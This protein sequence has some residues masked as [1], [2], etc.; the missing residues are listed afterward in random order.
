MTFNVL[1]F[2]A[3]WDFFCLIEYLS[4]SVNIT[5]L[6]KLTP[7]IPEI[8][9]RDRSVAWTEM[10]SWIKTWHKHL[11]F[12]MGMLEKMYLLYIL[13][14][15]KSHSLT[16][17]FNWLY[18]RQNKKVLSK[19]KLEAIVLVNPDP[20][21]AKACLDEMCVLGVCVSA[22]LCVWTKSN[23]L[24]SLTM[25]HGALITHRLKWHSDLSGE[26]ECAQTRTKT[27]TGGP[28]SEPPSRSSERLSWCV[29]KMCVCVF[30]NWL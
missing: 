20:V 7:E 23:K 22:V 16:W 17:L 12:K 19:R 3:F 2:L 13:F 9:N 21:L 5:R 24:Y 14:A 4:F 18:K 29:G 11:V 25:F 1:K 15:F 10:I 27:H 30:L 8:N 28:A 26:L 6:L